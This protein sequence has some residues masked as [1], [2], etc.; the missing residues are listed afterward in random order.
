[1]DSIAPYSKFGGF[2]KR[3]EDLATLEITDDDLIRLLEGPQLQAAEKRTFDNIGTFSKFGGFAKRSD[4]KPGENTDSVLDMQEN[5]DPKDK[6][7]VDSI[8]NYGRFGRFGKRS[9]MMVD[10]L[11]EVIKILPGSPTWRQ[12]L[13]RLCGPSVGYFDSLNAENLL[14]KAGGAIDDNQDEAVSKRGFDRISSSVFSR[15]GRLSWSPSFDERLD[16]PPDSRL[17]LLVSKAHLPF[18]RVARLLKEYLDNFHHRYGGGNVRRHRSV[19]QKR[20]FDRIS[21]GQFAK[22]G[23]K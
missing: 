16:T 2:G 9:D 14:Q 3:G 6:R 20:Q 12:D 4:S 19:S 7:K 5:D 8:A 13:E 18:C 1:M 22:W 11:G 15:F 17:P 23:K 21:Y 10:K